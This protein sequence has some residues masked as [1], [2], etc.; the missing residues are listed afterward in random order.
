MAKLGS[1]K[2]QMAAVRKRQTKAAK[3]T[4]GKMW[5]AFFKPRKKRKK[6]R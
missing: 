3:S 4:F 5:D 1:G 2:R 6:K